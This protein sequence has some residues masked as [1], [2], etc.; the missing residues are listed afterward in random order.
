MKKITAVAAMGCIA[1]LASACTGPSVSSEGDALLNGQTFSMALSG[2]PG[3]L[4]PSLSV[5][6]GAI[7]MNRFLYDTL[8][9]INASG[10]EEPYLAEKWEATTTKATFTLRKGITCSDGTALKA[11]TV[12]KN[13]DFIGD[14][15]NA[16]PFLGLAVQ[17]GT[18]AVGDDTS[19]I[20]T[21]TSGSPDPFLVRNLSLVA[22]VCDKGLANRQSLQ[23]GADGTGM[24]TL[25]KTAANDR[26]TLTRRSDYTW[27]PGDWNPKQDGLP[28]TVTIRIIENEGT[29]ANLLMSGELNAARISGADSARLNSAKLFKTTF[30]LEAGQ[31]FFNEATGRAAQDEAVRKALVAGVNLDDLRNVITGGAGSRSKG[32]ILAEPQVCPGDHTDGVFPTFNPETAK[33]ELDGAGW[34]ES[35]DK[36]RTKDG[37]TLTLKVLY[38]ASA[39]AQMA[40]AMELVQTSWKTLG[41]DV[42]LVAASDAQIGQVL[43]E[44]GDWDVSFV[45]L[46]LLVPSQWVPF[47]SGPASPNGFNSGSVDNAD[48]VKYADSAR[49]KL[50][51]DG[52]SDWN[53]AENALYKRVDVVPFAQ[54]DVPWFGKKATFGLE[55]GHLEPSSI[56]M[57]AN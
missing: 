37:K 53:A 1:L 56:R 29:A 20:V 5:L 7:Q 16:S 43:D 22:I 38:P 40:A 31:M 51:A 46:G 35:P 45:S 50:G 52:C 32:L 18:T 57:R 12:A 10:Q 19:G 30:P 3:T 15:K 27:G 6:S 24:F 55:V 36:G 17:P 41:V 8:T 4:D 23:A 14:E 11:S 49:N 33:A 21:V 9:T 28:D 47:V 42:Q 34:I 13:F 2:D 39:G 25:T 26:Y 44:T 54:K 48:Y